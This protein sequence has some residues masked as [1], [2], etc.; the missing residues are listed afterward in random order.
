MCFLAKHMPRLRGLEFQK[1]NSFAYVPITKL[2]LST[3]LA[4]KKS[5]YTFARGG[6]VMLRLLVF[7]GRLPGVQTVIVVN[8]YIAN[9]G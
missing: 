1:V 7:I 8:V 2:H 3:F 5:Q 4:Y 6:K 9:S